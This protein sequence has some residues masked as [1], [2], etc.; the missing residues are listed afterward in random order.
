MTFSEERQVVA[1]TQIVQSGLD[2]MDQF[3]RMMHDPFGKA[4]RRFDVVFGQV[5]LAQSAITLGHV[6]A[7]KFER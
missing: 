7:S 4:Q 2:A 6:P 3:E 5:R 1:F